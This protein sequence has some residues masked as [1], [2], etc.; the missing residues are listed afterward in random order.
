MCHFILFY[1]LKNFVYNIFTEY[2]LL[3]CVNWSCAKSFLTYYF[4]FATWAEKNE[5]E[6][7]TKKEEVKTCIVYLLFPEFTARV[8]EMI[9][10]Q[11]PMPGLATLNW[12]EGGRGSLFSSEGRT[13]SSGTENRG[14]IFLFFYLLLA[15][16]FFFIISRVT[17]ENGDVLL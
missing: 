8:C 13:Y 12:G 9:Y 17:E 15:R 6:E 1:H 4:I 14:L 7:K 11:N 2:N 16:S 5:E 3:F 10:F